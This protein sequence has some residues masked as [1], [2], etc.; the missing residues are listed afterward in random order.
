MTKPRMPAVLVPMA[1]AAIE[2]MRKRPAVPLI[3]QDKGAWVSPY[4]K[5]DDERWTALLFDTFGTRQRATVDM[6]FNQLQQLLESRWVEEWEQWVVDGDGLAALLSMVRAMRPRNEA[7]AAYAAQLVGL[8]MA[9]MKLASGSMRYSYGDPRSVAI[10]AKATRAFGDGLANM[11]RLKGKGGRSTQIIRV[12][13]HEHK[14]VHYH[15]GGSDNGG[16]AQAPSYRANTA[17]QTGRCEERPALPSPREDN[18]KVVPFSRCKGEAGV[19]DA[20]GSET[21]RSA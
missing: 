16:Q 6:F 11:R 10:I 1:D 2:R 9:T 4:A 12:E 13:K 14:H 20:R 3:A 15:G 18:G 7:E 17:T 8:H 21:K 19:P 5:Q